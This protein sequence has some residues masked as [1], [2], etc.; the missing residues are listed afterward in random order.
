MLLDGNPDADGLLVSDHD[1]LDIAVEADLAAVFPDDLGQ[2]ARDPFHPVDGIARLQNLLRLEQVMFG[3]I[4]TFPCRHVDGVGN[5]CHDHPKIREEFTNRNVRYILQK[6][7]FERPVV[8]CFDLRVAQHGDLL[9]QIPEDDLV[10]LRHRNQFRHVDEFL[11]VPEINGIAERPPVHL[12]ADPFIELRTRGLLPQFHQVQADIDPPA[13]SGIALITHHPAADLRK[14]VQ[15]Q[16]LL[17][18]LFGENRRNTQTGDTGADDNRIIFV[19]RHTI[20]PMQYEVKT[21][22][23]LT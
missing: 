19:F 2:S 6:P 13:R 1:F 11:A 3:D 5:G 15:H 22:A 9:Q 7:F 8:P 12:L 18:P 4:E 21:F 10:F 16:H 23:T 20:S 14:P 17:F